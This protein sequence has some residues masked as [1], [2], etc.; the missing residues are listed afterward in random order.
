ML[1]FVRRGNAASSVVSVVLLSM[2]SFTTLADQQGDNETYDGLVPVPGAR[3]QA[4]FIDPRADF[5]V[6]KRVVVFEPRVAFRANWERD[7][8]RNS[9]IRRVSARDMERIKADVAELFKEVFIERLEANDGY[10]VVDVIGD[11]V[12]VIRPSI[13]DLNINVPNTSPTAPTQSI[14]A[15][16]GSATLFVELFDSVSGDIIGRAA[17]R[18][19]IG[20]AQ[21]AFTLRGGAANRQEARQM[22][23]RWA[24][25]LR[26]F[27]DSHYTGK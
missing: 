7:Q 4:A 27:L 12:L 13:I 9:R 23:T 16:A 19:T 20:Q 18:R 2:I 3:V 10:E 6:F 8:N 24:D 21:G 1:S 11:D 14:S 17:D 26:E 25:K 15:T 5:S 22:F